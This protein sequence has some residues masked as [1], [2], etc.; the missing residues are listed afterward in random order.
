MHF[1]HYLQ[2][3]DQ[4]DLLYAKIRIDVKGK[5]ISKLLAVAL[6]LLWATRAIPNQ[7]YIK[8]LERSS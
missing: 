3:L 8:W 1:L 6:C 7:K 5:P 4:W 2:I